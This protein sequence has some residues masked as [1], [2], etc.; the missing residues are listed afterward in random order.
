MEIESTIPNPVIKFLGQLASVVDSQQDTNFT[1]IV[2]VAINDYL[3][4]L[5]EITPPANKK[6]YHKFD[7]LVPKQLAK[8]EFVYQITSD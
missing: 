7:L 2:D 8:S 4:L 1:S 6:I 3:A 5:Q